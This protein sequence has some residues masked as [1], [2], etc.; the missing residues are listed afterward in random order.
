M[1][2]AFRGNLQISLDYP[3]SINDNYRLLKG[4]NNQVNALRV[5]DDADFRDLDVFQGFLKEALNES[6]L[7]SSEH[8]R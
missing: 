3:G 7:D 5:A 6:I 1:V 4:S 2:K 8:A